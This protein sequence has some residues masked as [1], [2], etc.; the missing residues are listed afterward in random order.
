[1]TS[2][3]GVLLREAQR[4]F[5]EAMLDGYCGNCEKST[6][7]TTPNNDK[8]IIY[9]SVDFKVEDR[10]SKKPENS[11]SERLAGTTTI[12]IKENGIWFPF[13]RM[14]YGGYYPKHVI[15]FLKSVLAKTYARQ[16]F[17]G[18]RGHYLV[19]EGTLLYKN[20]LDEDE[21]FSQF[22][23]QEE[24]VDRRTDRTL[25]FHKYF[26]MAILLE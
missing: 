13:W 18:G 7:I 15:P 2:E 3:I 9:K 10:Y 16:I 25:G 4:V 6:K 23:G 19:A 26:G 22:S 14:F 11:K 12:F 24:I 8:V 21:E 17:V 5:F 1:M 20:I